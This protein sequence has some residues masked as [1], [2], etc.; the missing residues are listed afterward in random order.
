M[1]RKPPGRAVGR[2]SMRQGVVALADCS[3]LRSP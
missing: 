1:R 3:I 2:C